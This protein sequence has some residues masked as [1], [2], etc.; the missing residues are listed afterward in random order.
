ME[1]LLMAQKSCT[2]WYGKY[3]SIYRVLA[4][5]KRWLA[6][7]FLKHQKYPL[8]GKYFVDWTD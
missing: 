5:S 6:L 2:S 8:F 4:P 7:G 1:L 3:P